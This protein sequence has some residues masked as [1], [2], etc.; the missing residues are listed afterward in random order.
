[1]DSIMFGTYCVG[2]SAIVNNMR[3]NKNQNE[4]EETMKDLRE[5]DLSTD[6]LRQEHID[7]KDVLVLCKFDH[8]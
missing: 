3:Q 7:D 1:M 6:K 4:Y 5:Y 8:E 2:L